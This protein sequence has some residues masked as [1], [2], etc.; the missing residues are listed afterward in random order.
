MTSYANAKRR[1]NERV[2]AHLHNNSD[3]WHRRE[4]RIMAV[5]SQK[6]AWLLTFWSGIRAVHRRNRRIE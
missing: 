4:V 5:A 6:F 1:K 2:D 3:N